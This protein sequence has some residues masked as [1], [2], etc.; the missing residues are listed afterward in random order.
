MITVAWRRINPKG[1]RGADLP[2]GCDDPIPLLYGG[3]GVPWASILRTAKILWGA[4]GTKNL[5]THTG[6]FGCREGWRRPMLAEGYG[7]PE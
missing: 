2:M 4:C 6:S 3:V 5:V 7:L 1:A